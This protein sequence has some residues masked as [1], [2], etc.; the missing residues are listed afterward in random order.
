MKPHRVPLLMTEE[1]G[2]R[3]CSTEVY[4][5]TIHAGKVCSRTML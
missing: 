5:L 1:V 2:E 4:E 3:K